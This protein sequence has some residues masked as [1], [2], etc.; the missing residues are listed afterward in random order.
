VEGL[1]VGAQR[2]RVARLYGRALRLELLQPLRARAVVVV[3]ASVAVGAVAAAAA[4]GRGRVAAAAADAAAV[5]ADAAA[6]AKA[7]SPLDALD[8]VVER[9]AV[10][11]LCFGFGSW[12]RDV[13]SDLC[14]AKKG[15]QARAMCVWGGRATKPPNAQTQHHICNATHRCA[16]SAASSARAPACAA[17]HSSSVSNS[18]TTS[19]VRHPKDFFDRKMSP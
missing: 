1:V 14:Y 11:C 13:L 19:I 15:K 12:G 9:V 3:A 16:R 18:G 4:A 10:F 6:A 17:S 8:L 7:Q 2:F 5:G